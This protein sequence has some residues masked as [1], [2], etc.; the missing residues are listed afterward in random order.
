MER[1][2]FAFLLEAAEVHGYARGQLQVK[3]LHILLDSKQKVV[4]F[5]SMNDT[6][7]VGAYYCTAPEILQRDESAVVH[8]HGDAVPGGFRAVPD[9]RPARHRGN[10]AW[11]RPL[12]SAIRLPMYYIESG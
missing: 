7:F 9:G 3:L 6:P 4:E 5:A 12:C 1:D 8:D 2:W 11:H 10:G